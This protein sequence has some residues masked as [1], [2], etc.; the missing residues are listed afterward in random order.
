RRACVD[1]RQ[2]RS[3]KQE[4]DPEDHRRRIRSSPVVAWC[5]QIRHTEMFE[6]DSQQWDL[7]E[8]D[9]LGSLRDAEAASNQRATAMLLNNLA[10]VY[11][12]EG[13]FL[14]ADLAHKRCVSVLESL[15][16]P[17]SVAQ[18]LANRA[19]LYRT[20]GHYHEGERLFQCAW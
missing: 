16:E 7:C 19:G 10:V 17:R 3:P 1:S 4:A 20:F 5:A 9:I 8:R 18:S 15:G 11:H 2:L 14:D 6:D 13:R 12:V